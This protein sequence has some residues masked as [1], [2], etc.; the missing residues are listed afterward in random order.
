MNECALRLERDLRT[1]RDRLRQEM[2]GREDQCLALYLAEIVPDTVE[3]GNAG[4]GAGAARDRAGGPRKP[5][6]IAQNTRS[7]GSKFE[8]TGHGWSKT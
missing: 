8:V 7:I 4:D 3:S 2:R 1:I 6:S 5:F